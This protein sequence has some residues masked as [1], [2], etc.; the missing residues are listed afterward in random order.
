ME[1]EFIGVCDKYGDTLTAGMVYTNT[2]VIILCI[3][4]MLMKR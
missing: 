2:K 4:S 1:K 3:R